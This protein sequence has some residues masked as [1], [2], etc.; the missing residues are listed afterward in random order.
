MVG[1]RC[2]TAN[3]GA[4]ILLVHSGSGPL[5]V[6]K[7]EM[8]LWFIFSFDH[9][10]FF[11]THYAVHRSNSFSFLILKRTIFMSSKEVLIVMDNELQLW[12]LLHFAHLW[13]YYIFKNTS[14]CC[15]CGAPICSLHHILSNCSVAL[16]GERYTWRH[17]S[18]LSEVQKAIHRH[19]EDR[20]ANV[21]KDSFPHISSCFV[22]AGKSVVTAKKK[23]LALA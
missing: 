13:P 18:V 7:I 5:C 22:P 17:D 12:W 21:V 20:N 9:L 6:N 1:K 23:Q 8:V 14:S 4:A 16:N 10:G 11:L 15:L 19:V 2:S 3:T